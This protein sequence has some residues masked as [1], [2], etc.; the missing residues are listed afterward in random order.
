M[1]DVAPIHLISKKFQALTAWPRARVVGFAKFE[2]RV[3]D[4]LKS[5]TNCTN[6]GEAINWLNSPF[7][8]TGD[9]LMIQ[10][11]VGEME[12]LK[13]SPLKLVISEVPGDL[14]K[15]RE[16]LFHLEDKFP[17]SSS[18]DKREF[19]FL[20]DEVVL[21]LLCGNDNDKIKSQYLKL[22]FF[23]SAEYG[24]LLKENSARLKQN[25]D[26]DFMSNFLS[27]ISELASHARAIYFLSRLLEMQTFRRQPF[28]KWTFPKM[29]ENAFPTIEIN[30]GTHPSLNFHPYFTASDNKYFPQPV[31]IK[32]GHLAE[33]GARMLG[34]V[35]TGPNE[36]GKTTILKMS[37]LMILL[38]QM[39]AI[40][41]A[42]NAAISPF[43]NILFY[44]S[45]GNQ[46]I[47]EGL[48][49]FAGE[50][51]QWRDLDLLT[52]KTILF[53]DEPNTTTDP[54]PARALLF[55]TWEKLLLPRKV[56]WVMAT[57]YRQGLEEFGK[58][59]SE[60]Q[61]LQ[62]GKSFDP[63]DPNK[64]KSYEISQ[65]IFEDVYTLAIAGQYLPKDVIDG[66]NKYL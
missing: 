7:C 17:L 64:A 34:T 12:T 14:Q 21:K 66:A 62:V 33:A 61:M 55:S 58:R 24:N 11:A 57:H 31:S 50:C 3:V 41:P 38:A 6:I 42:E 40:V 27:G 4:S 48:S 20:I 59:F 22:I 49:G 13:Y 23:T 5:F 26:R 18:E 65:G 60:V 36:F 43:E 25:P 45:W 37:A 32:A 9:V 56:V 8:R 30:S 54:N 15:W 52:E 51:S 2:D 35:I 19:G 1:I 46:S 28:L 39:G 53:Y 16:N 44:S 10:E 47:G 63:N 29:I